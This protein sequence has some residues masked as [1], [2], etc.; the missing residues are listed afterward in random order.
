MIAAKHGLRRL[1]ISDNG[2]W[3]NP[4][5]FSLVHWNMWGSRIRA[6]DFDEKVVA[7]MKLLEVFPLLGDLGESVRRAIDCDII[8][9]EVSWK[10]DC[11]RYFGMLQQDA[12]IPLSVWPLVMARVN[13]DQFY[14]ERQ[15]Y[16]ISQKPSLSPSI[17]YEMLHGPALAER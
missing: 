7:I 4:G 3:G 17:L 12:N 5:F 14:P 8:P 15:Y 2:G 1:D 9:L 16:W 13:M 10:L 6:I 11:N